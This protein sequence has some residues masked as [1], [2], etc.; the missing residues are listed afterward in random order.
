MDIRQLFR[1]EFPSILVIIL[2]NQ[3]ET[4]GPQLLGIIAD[5]ANNRSKHETL[6]FSWTTVTIQLNCNV[7]C[8][9]YNEW[10][11][12]IV[13]TVFN[14]NTMCYKLKIT[15][16]LLAETRARLAAVETLSKATSIDKN[17]L[18][19]FS[20]MCTSWGILNLQTK[21]KKKHK[22]KQTTEAAYI[23]QIMMTVGR[24]TVLQRNN[25]LKMR[26]TKKKQ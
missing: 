7:S 25:W 13:K 22:N 12:L 8:L 15:E 21:Y 5:S 24:K 14:I 9:A 26:W 11:Y 10:S 3:R 20:V 1:L 18:R 2:S 16:K 19:R 6:L 17:V 23:K 4:V